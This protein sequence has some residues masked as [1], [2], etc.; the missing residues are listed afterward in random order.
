M[1]NLLDIKDIIIIITVFK[2]LQQKKL[3]N[4]G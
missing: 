3:P 2:L 1:Y 4:I